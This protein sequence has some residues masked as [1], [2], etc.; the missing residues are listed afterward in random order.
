MYGNNSNSL[1]SPII[2]VNL[3]GNVAP[4]VKFKSELPAYR[5]MQRYE[6]IKMPYDSE[7]FMYFSIEVN[8][9][10]DTILLYLKPENIFKAGQAL[11]TVFV[12][13]DKYPR[14]REGNY[15]WKSRFSVRDWTTDGF[16]MIIP[17]Y[18]CD[19]GTCYIGIQPNKGKFN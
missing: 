18:I 15:G 12:Q 3:E 11:Y 8:N 17:P 1:T 14:D 16:K 2:S 5:Y 19:K 13:K 4:I 9:N 7:G 10:D 6:P